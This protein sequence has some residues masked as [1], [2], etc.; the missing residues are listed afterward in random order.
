MELSFFD[1]IGRCDPEHGSSNHLVGESEI[2]PQEHIIYGCEQES[3]DADA[4]CHDEEL[5]S[6]PH[7]NIRSEEHTSE[8]QSRFDLVCRL[9]LEKK[10]QDV[11]W[12]EP[13][14]TK[15]HERVKVVAFW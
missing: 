8:L 11:W 2:S 15:P 13:P 5:G 7:F 12:A 10:K 3:W 6:C 9:L 1:E 14:S 4:D